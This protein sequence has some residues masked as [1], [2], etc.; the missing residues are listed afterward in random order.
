MDYT[1]F[2]HLLKSGERLV[3]ADGPVRFGAVPT[4]AWTPG[5]IIE[6]TRT[7]TLPPGVSK[8]GL[9][10]L[11]GLYDAESGQRLPATDRHGARF[12]DDAIPLPVNATPIP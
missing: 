2:V 10:V 8:D 7:M 3:Q 5:A 1:V 11:V 4:T 12:P 9:Q 6:D